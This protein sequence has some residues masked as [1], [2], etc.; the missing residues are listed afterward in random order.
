MSDRPPKVSIGM[1]VRNGELYLAQAIAAVLGQDFTNLELVI[2]DNGSCDATEEICRQAAAEDDRVRYLRSDDNRGAAWN[3]N[4][5]VAVAQGTYFAWAAH[6]DLRTP[7]SVR[8]CAEV[9]DRDPSVSLCFG[10]GVDIDRDGTQMRRY[11]PLAYA[12]GPTPAGR[13]RDVLATPSPCFEVFGLMRRS[14]LL[15]TAMIGAYTSSDRTLLFELALLGRF[16]EVPHIL[17]LHRQH[18]DR[19]VFTHRHPRDRD[20]W[21]DPKRAQRITLPRWRLLAEHIRAVR[22]VPLSSA[23]RREAFAAVA[24]WACGRSDDL[25]RDLV[26]WSRHKLARS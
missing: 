6:D 17:F 18:D 14:Q 2:S 13:A 10:H 15:S 12:E 25:A 9:L 5:V 11:P 22:R 19:S 24:M 21:F 20:S 23:Q 1:P 16:H 3:F 7:D 8:R 4:H 26:A